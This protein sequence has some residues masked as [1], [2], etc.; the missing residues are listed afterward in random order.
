MQYIDLEQK[1]NKGKRID[2]ININ[3]KLK[4]KIKI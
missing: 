4:T 1:L 3:F 2:A